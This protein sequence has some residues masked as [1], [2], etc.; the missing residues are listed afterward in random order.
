[1]EGRFVL[2]ILIIVWLREL[3]GASFYGIDG[4]IFGFCEPD[5][6]PWWSRDATPLGIAFAEFGIP[7]PNR[8]VDALVRIH[9]L[10]RKL[11]EHLRVWREIWVDCKRTRVRTDRERHCAVGS[12]SVKFHDGTVD[13]LKDGVLRHLR[14]SFKVGAP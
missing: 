2:P 1:M 6:D 12:G 8:R 11:H 14:R 10:P 7:C 5:D 13:V 9:S 3:L 4:R